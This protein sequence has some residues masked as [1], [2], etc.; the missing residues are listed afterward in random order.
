MGDVKLADFGV[1]GQLTNTT[2]KR[3]TFVG[4]PFWMA[5][6]VIKQ[7]AYDAKADVWSLGITAI[8]LAKGEPPN[9]DLH[10]MR[11]LF[12]IPKNNPPQL[13][14][15]FSKAFKEFVEACLNKD[16]ENRPSAKE[17]MRH[18]YIKKAKKNSHLMDLIDRYKKWR[19]TR[20]D[21]SE[22]DSGGESGGDTNNEDDD[23]D[24]N[25]T[26][27]GPP[28]PGYYTDSIG[29]SQPINSVTN[30]DRDLSPV[31]DVS[32]PASRGSSDRSSRSPSKDVRG[33]SPEK[34]IIPTGL[35]PA[36]SEQQIVSTRHLHVSSSLLC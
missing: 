9:S 33:R 19:L 22:T 30:G 5:P 2:S 15:N 25:M 3:N 1:A 27:K 26:V 17:L 11:V 28:P 29:Y 20:G 13:T 6:E 34:Q 24:W 4:T 18:P 36:K 8:E 16:P 31:K 21:E 7:S 23:T 12:L 14:G 32:S 35:S 10:P